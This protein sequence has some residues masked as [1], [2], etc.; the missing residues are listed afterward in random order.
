MSKKNYD[1]NDNVKEDLEVDA[2]DEV[3]PAAAKQIEEYKKQLEAKNEEIE[4]LKAASK[5]KFNTVSQG[6]I[7]AK[8]EPKHPVHAAL[9][10][11]GQIL[12]AYKVTESMDKKGPPSSI[13]FEFLDKKGNVNAKFKMNDTPKAFQ[14]YFDWF[15]DKAKAG[16]HANKILGKDND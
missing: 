15:D 2:Q 4:R 6:F 5:T 10:D 9:W 12:P 1:Q 3:N 11:K 16:K 8:I 14:K 7:V 13:H